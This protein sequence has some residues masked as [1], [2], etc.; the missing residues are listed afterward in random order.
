MFHAS[1]DQQSLKVQMIKP[2]QNI[3][4]RRQLVMTCN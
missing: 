4:Y 3:A 2:E 1:S